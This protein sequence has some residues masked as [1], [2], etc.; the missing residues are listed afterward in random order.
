MKGERER[1]RDEANSGLE[2][3][4]ESFLMLLFA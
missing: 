2:R 1:E 3:A 4:W